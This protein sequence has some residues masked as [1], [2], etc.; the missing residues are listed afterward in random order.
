M[1]NNDIITFKALEQAMMDTDIILSYDP[2]IENLLLAS[3]KTVD[4]KC[5]TKEDCETMIKNINVEIKS[6]N[7]AM[8]NMVLIA[9]DLKNNKI[10]KDEFVSSITPNVNIL[11]SQCVGLGLIAKESLT[12]NDISV[13]DENI[14]IVR[15]FM[16]KTKDL[17]IE[18]MNSFNKNDSSLDSFINACE[19]MQITEEGFNLDT[20]KVFYTEIKEVMIVYKQA[21]KLSRKKDIVSLLESKKLFKSIIPMI[22][23]VKNKI[24]KL[25]EKTSIWSNIKGTFLPM[26]KLSYD[27]PYYYSGDDK[28]MIVQS[29]LTYMSDEKLSDAMSKSTGSTLKSRIQMRL[30]IFIKTIEKYLEYINED[31]DDIKKEEEKKVVKESFATIME[32]LNEGINVCCDKDD[33]EDYSEDEEE[34]DDDI[35]EL[36]DSLD[37]N[38]ED[39]DVIECKK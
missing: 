26:I 36:I 28:K 30:N 16:I 21:R 35:D 17:I 7:T 5:R 31:I 4:N 8:E 3:K 27:I 2:V 29:G 9:G 34:K 32:S 19:S 12:E 13:A 37:D 18:K 20:K 15:N 1:I 25:D 10:N 6:F 24:N 22:H 33:D 38:N 39:E 14:S 23:D 11:K